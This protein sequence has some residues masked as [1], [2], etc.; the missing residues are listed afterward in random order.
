MNLLLDNIQKQVHYS[1]HHVVVVGNGIH[2]PTPP[3]AVGVLGP[4]N[5]VQPP[6]S[7]VRIFL[8]ARQ[9]TGMGKVLDLGIDVA[10]VE[11]ALPV[12]LAE[13]SL[14]RVGL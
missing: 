5:V 6:Q 3:P 2:I 8:V 13:S 12:M 9:F 7:T 1:R 10:V 14:D 4:K 11:R